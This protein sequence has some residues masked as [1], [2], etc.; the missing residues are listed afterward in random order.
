MRRLSVLVLLPLAASACN[1][2]TSADTER[3]TPEQTV[4]RQA[5]QIER[6][7]AG[8]AE[9]D[10]QVKA[11]R[12][13]LLIAQGLSDFADAAVQIAQVKLGRY[14]HMAD[15]DKARPGPDGVKV[16]LYLFDRDNDKIKRAGRIELKV[17]DLKEERKLGHWIF[18]PPRALEHWKAGWPLDCYVFQLP[19]QEPPGEIDQVDLHWQFDA[20]TGQRFTGTQTL[21][22]ATLDTP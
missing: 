21:H 4:A 16:Y 7:K 13:Q 22:V 3:E 5:T 9:R 17:F 12:D 2:N 10:A 6:L 18:D 14:S 20:L 15:F 19:W 11:L 8:L 1:H